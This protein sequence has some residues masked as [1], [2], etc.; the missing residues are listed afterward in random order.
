M[1]GR[2]QPENGKGGGGRRL[3]P[4]LRDVTLWRQLGRTYALSVIAGAIAVWAGIPLPWMLGPFFAWAAMSL[5][6]LRP[7]L[8]PMGREL[9]Q[10]AIGVVVGMRFTLPLLL[11]TMSLLPAMFL[12]TIYV[13]LL[14]MSAAVLFGWLARVDHVT[15]FFAT[16]AG[17]VADMARVAQ[18]FGGVTQ[19]VAVVHALRV[20]CVVGLVPFI[21]V[22]L[23]ERG[24]PPLIADE[25]TG[26]VWL[27]PVALLLG[28]LG[29]RALKPTP[30]PNPWLVGPIF[31]GM[32]LGISGVFH[33]HVPGVVIVVAQI[34]LGTWLGAQFRREQLGALPRVTAAGLAISLYLVVGAALGA[35]VFSAATGVA[36]TTAFLGFA[37]AAVTEMVLVAKFMDLEAE[38]VTAFHVLRI[39]IVASTVLLVFR[40]YGKLRGVRLEP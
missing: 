8:M 38:I 13:I 34:A 19:S 32:A 23:G 33:V 28:Y 14:T 39:A 27:V 15:A 16:A 40:L 9:G 36:F 22:F 11:A 3:P 18:K 26:T 37:P 4:L 7:T 20:A 24:T 30:I 6:G 1:S 12:G 2:A 10:V 35:W 29:A 21:V 31:V 5:M 17:G 25:V